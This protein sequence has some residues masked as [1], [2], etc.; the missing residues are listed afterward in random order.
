MSDLTVTKLNTQESPLII[1]FSV[2][3]QQASQ[4]F[5]RH[6]SRNKLN[7]TEFFEAA[8]QGRIK[9]VYFPAYILDCKI[10][11]HLT[12][13]CTKRDGEKTDSFIAKRE[14]DSEFSQM[15]SVAGDKV[16]STLFT[17]LEPYDFET[18]TEYD[19]SVAQNTQIQQFTLTPEELF[20]RIRPD[21]ENRAFFSAKNTVSGY[22]D[23]KPTENIFDFKSITAKHVLLP[24]WVLTC[25]YQGQRYKLYMNGQTGKVA[26]VPPRSRTKMLAF[27]GAGTAACAVIGQLIWMAVRALW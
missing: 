24:M 2:S 12:A 4:L 27:L 14:L 26:G 5:A 16:D 25:K 3:A 9:P 13:E 7:P 10:T 8:R 19:S 15:V 1:P 23:E 6:I 11:T 18:L 20:E 17:L 21:L 22:T